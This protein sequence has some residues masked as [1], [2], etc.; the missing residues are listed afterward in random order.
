[1]MG[2]FIGTGGVVFVLF[3]ASLSGSIV[4]IFG[5]IFGHTG[6]KTP[7]PFGPFLSGAGL[8]YIFTGE[9]LIDQFYN[10]TSFLPILF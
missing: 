1:M 7:I 6:S 9:D 2:T 8:L 3:F 10:L 4:A 5:L